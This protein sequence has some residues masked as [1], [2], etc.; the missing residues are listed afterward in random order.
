MIL[1]LNCYNMSIWW[2]FYQCASN[3]IIS[4]FNEVNLV[5][6]IKKLWCKENEECNLMCFPI[7][8]RTIW[9]FFFWG[10]CCIFFLFLSLDLMFFFMCCYVGNWIVQFFGFF[11]IF[12]IFLKTLFLVFYTCQRMFF[13]TLCIGNFHPFLN[14][15]CHKIWVG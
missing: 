11:F 4:Y 3:T 5:C 8:P 1:K 15:L 7:A 10:H 6:K 13:H 9:F 14:S 2:P 12:F